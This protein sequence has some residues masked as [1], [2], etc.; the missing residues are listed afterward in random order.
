MFRSAVPFFHKILFFV[1]TLGALVAL[2]LIW[3]IPTLRS[4]YWSASVLALE[5]VKRARSEVAFSLE[6]IQRD[7]ARSAEEIAYEPERKK[8]VLERALKY[9][10][11]IRS[12]GVAGEDGKETML[13]DRFAYVP[14]SALR[15]WRGESYFTRA[16]DGETSFG[17][18]F[19][20]PESEPH[21]TLAIPVSRA[22]TVREVLVADINLRDLVSSVRT[23]EITAGHIYV[24]DAAGYQ[25]I[26]PNLSELL[27]RRNFLSRP[28]VGKV[29][30]DR[31]IANGL[32][33][34]DG[35]TNE[36]G[37]R[38][39]TVGMPIPAAGLS[40]FFETPRSSALV[41]VRQAVLFALVTI[42]L[43]IVIVLLTIQ[44]A[45]RLRRLNTRLREFLKENYEVGKILVRRDRELTWANVRLEEFLREL[46]NAGKMLVRRD[47]ELTQAN[48]R[49]EELDRVKSEFVSIAAHQ[50]R[51]P[52][53]GV[54]W[55][56]QT[57]LD[58]DTGP[59]TRDQR[60]IA[61]TGL[62]ATMRMI[63]LV[64]DL[65]S[66]ARIEEGRFG[67]RLRKQSI[68]SLIRDIAARHRTLAAQKGVK[69]SLEI[70]TDSVLPAI[71]F[72]EEKLTI[73]FD[74]LL[75]NALKYTE[76][77]GTITL[78]V[79]P[80]EGR[81][82]FEA[83]DTGIGIPKEQVH[84]VFTKF[85]RA[86]NAIRFHTSGTGLGLYVARNIVEAHGGAMEVRSDEGKGSV[87]SFFLPVV[88]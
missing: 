63:G 3:L 25:I 80:E 64:N 66:V 32:A 8:K 21:I 48:A 54:R 38:T 1:S 71:A 10:P 77:G 82:R 55:S 29:V 45:D 69:F 41:G 52:L 60:R 12:I 49:L 30:R 24:V 86:D 19:I 27:R 51:T 56:Y 33:A 74:N 9:N 6:T 79:R 83:V 81:L 87:L 35:Y 43:G 65:L 17:S 42:A 73:V 47:L 75:D 62:G 70:P 7:L 46:D 28:I 61:E 78:R 67:I 2:N 59:L 4:T 11:G 23:P 20:S 40:I 36:R 85:F 5:T 88:K 39:F 14:P 22:G 15:D 26:H 57:M 58:P 68:D 16:R 44:G 76:P 18:V 13:I 84:R 34:D 37:E 50:L 53:T 31:V 72:D